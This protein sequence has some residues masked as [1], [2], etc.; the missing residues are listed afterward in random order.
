MEKKP[1]GI[2]VGIPSNRTHRL[3]TCLLN[4]LNA[5][6]EENIAADIL[7]VDGSGQAEQNQ[8][9]ATHASEKFDTNVTVLDEKTHQAAQKSE[10]R[11][12][13][14]G[15]F[16][17][18]R[19]TILQHAVHQR[20]HA[21]F[22]DDDVIPTDTL[23]SRF[24][25]HFQSHKIVVGAYAGK[26]T[27][28]VF[29]MDKVHRA[30]SDFAE[31]KLGRMQAVAKAREGFCGLS[32]EWSPS[33]EGYSG[34]CLGVAL[35]A[36]KKYC[37]YPSR[38]RMEDGMYCILAKHFVQE[39]AFMP[40]LPE[41]PVGVHK[42]HAGPVTTLVDYYL[43]ALQGACIG[44]SVQYAL[45]KYGDHPGPDQIK[46][47]CKTAPKDLHEQFNPEKTALRREQQKPLDEAMAALK[48]PEL[49]LQYD[50]F[51]HMGLKDAIV[52]DLEKYV[53]RFFDAQDAWKKLNEK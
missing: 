31:G 11:F 49:Q 9:F 43:N 42:P 5:L 26:R 6:E 32:D 2:L 12:L 3:R 7:V 36:A 15:P 37:F 10:F 24:R 35:D 39:N 52:P 4:V 45:E 21:V 34:G 28:A 33:V 44:K 1:T 20:K 17:G 48:E 47:A 16:G 13:F 27:G 46:T 14:D 30:L 40:F 51:V 8:A 50:R 23:F 18:P 19:N 53:Q 25:T 41:A 22:L 29:L 38:F